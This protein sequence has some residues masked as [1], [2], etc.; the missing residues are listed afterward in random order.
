MTLI[1]TTSSDGIR[2]PSDFWLRVASA[3]HSL[4]VLDYDEALVP[5]GSQ[6]MEAGPNPRVLELIGTIASHGRCT[7][8]VVSRRPLAELRSRLGPLAIQLIGEHG[9]QMLLRDGRVEE[10]S[11]PREW[12][13]ALQQAA[14]LAASRGMRERLSCTRSSVRVRSADL[15]PDE[16]RSFERTCTQL[17]ADLA[18]ARGLLLTRHDGG[19]ELRAP[20]RSKGTAV[21][22]AIAHCG[23]NPL[24]VYVGNDEDSFRAVH[25]FGFGIRVGNDVRPTDAVGTLASYID[26]VSFLERWHRNLGILSYVHP[27]GIGPTRSPNNSLEDVRRHAEGP[28]SVA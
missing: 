18:F 1:P 12:A 4:L 16:A 23:I 5:S 15:E 20:S 27:L 26:V 11:V 24:S 10:Y 21:Q 6:G 2:L 9:W 17:W 13:E 25:H 28:R 8:A 3:R 14:L 19:I 7:V 22:H